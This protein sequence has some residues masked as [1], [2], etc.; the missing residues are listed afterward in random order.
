MEVCAEIESVGMNKSLQLY[1]FP[2]LKSTIIDRE[3]VIL[4]D[5]VTAIWDN[6]ISM[7]LR[8]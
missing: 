8:G 2:A 4:F 7:N 3:R 5:T 1:Q 6:K